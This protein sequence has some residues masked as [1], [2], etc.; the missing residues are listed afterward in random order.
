M[1]VFLCLQ[2]QRTQNHLVKES[3]GLLFKPVREMSPFLQWICI[4]GVIL[5]PM[6]GKYKSAVTQ[7]FYFHFPHNNLLRKL[8]LVTPGCSG[9]ERGEVTSGNA[10]GSISGKSGLPHLQSSEAPLPLFITL[11]C[12]NPL[13]TYS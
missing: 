6:S 3:C 4:I 9:A 11:Q 2:G 13:V 12:G 10:S 5:L 1:L 7:D 8:N